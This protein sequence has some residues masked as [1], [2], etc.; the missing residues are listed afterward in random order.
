MKPPQLKQG[1]GL[2]AFRT[3]QRGE[4]AATCELRATGLRLQPPWCPSAGR[5][6]G[7]PLPCQGTPAARGTYPMGFPA[8]WKSFRTRST[9]LLTLQSFP[10]TANVLLQRQASSQAGLLSVCSARDRRVVPTWELV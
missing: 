5:H 4:A 2:R 7:P 6:G 3:T 1:K 8:L 10:S 9:S